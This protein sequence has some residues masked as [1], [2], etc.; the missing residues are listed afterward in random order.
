ML[1][2]DMTSELRRR[3][4]LRPPTHI[5]LN[6]IQLEAG[7]FISLQMLPPVNNKMWHDIWSSEKRIWILD[8]Y[9][10]DEW[11][12]K[13]YIFKDLFLTTCQFSSVKFSFLCQRAA[14]CKQA[15]LLWVRKAKKSIKPGRNQIQGHILVGSLYETLC[16]LVNKKRQRWHCELCKD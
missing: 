11:I 8:L 2:C 9:P 13:E 6:L 15:K 5:K 14:M 1:R 10:Q 3:L 7:I 12:L 4:Q 16:K